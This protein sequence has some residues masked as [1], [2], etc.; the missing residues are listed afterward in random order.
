VLVAKDVPEVEPAVPA[1]A[2]VV[3][4]PEVEEDAGASAANAEVLK[5]S[6]SAEMRNL[7]IGKSF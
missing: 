1:S 4:S 6:A 5:A 7:F 3:V 2:E